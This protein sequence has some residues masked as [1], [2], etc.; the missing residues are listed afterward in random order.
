MKAVL[1]LVDRS[2]PSDANVLITGEHGT[3]RRS[4]PDASTP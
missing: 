1:E 4:S 3:A 2:P